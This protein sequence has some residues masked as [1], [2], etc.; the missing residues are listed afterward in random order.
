MFQIKSERTFPTATNTV[1]LVFVAVFYRKSIVS[2]H[3]LLI[4]TED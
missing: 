4:E 1:K 2:I 3:P